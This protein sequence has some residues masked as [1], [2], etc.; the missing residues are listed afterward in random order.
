MRDVAPA[1]TAAALAWMTERAISRIEPDASP[2][3][4]DA[5]ADALGEVVWRT[6]YR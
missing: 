2:A 5:C 6:L 3:A 4:L 1:P